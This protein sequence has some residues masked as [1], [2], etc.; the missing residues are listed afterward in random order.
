MPHISKLAPLTLAAL[1]AL[2]IAATST[3]AKKPLDHSAFDSWETA[4]NDLISSDGQWAAFAVN[5]QEGDGTLTF[6]NTRN[7]RRIV[8]ER[9]HTPAFTAD[10]AWGVALIR[11]PY[12]VTR[13][14]RIKKTAS[15]LMPADSLAIV[16]LKTGAIT[17]IGG[18][19][20]Y[21]VSRDKGSLIAFESC[22]TTL[23]SPSVLADA[24]AGLPLIVVDPATGNNKTVKWV[25]QYA[26]SDAGNCVA[27][28][29]R[30]NA[31]D[32]LTTDGVG[33]VQIADT[34]FTLLD[35][36]RKFYGNIALDPKGERLAYVASD[37]TTDTGTKRAQLYLADLHRPYED[38]EMV[39]EQITGPRGPN[40]SMPHSS[41][42]ETQAKLMEEWGRMQR[43]SAGKML[44]VNQYTR[45]EF[46]HDG[47]RLI[48]VFRHV[49]IQDVCT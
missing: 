39:F 30:G 41:D 35:R 4:T 29:L 45:P 13:Q 14:A 33:V 20:S 22:D 32:S 16:N 34:S 49:K 11:P 25:K 3:A 44:F 37:D 12:A 7:N 6:Y 9:A 18:V 15:H 2:A 24:K 46:S 19:K 47:T 36:D 31:T 38:P 17:R 1:S 40:Y 10:G 5:P 21:R 42:P 27:F 23:V 8:I 48:A 26:V 28:T 43:E